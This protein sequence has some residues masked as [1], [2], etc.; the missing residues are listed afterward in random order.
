VRCCLAQWLADWDDADI[1]TLGGLMARFNSST[2]QVACAAP[3][4][5]S[6]AG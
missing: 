1:A 3:A 5:G 6:A 4:P 2:P